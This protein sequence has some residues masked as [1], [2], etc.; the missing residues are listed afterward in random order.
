MRSPG[1]TV[2]YWVR[3]FCLPPAVFAVF[4]FLGLALQF[5]N[6]FAHV[7]FEP[8]GGFILALVW[9]L[10]AHFIA[11]DRKPVASA[12]AFGVGA[13]FAWK[14]IG[15]SYYPENHPQAYQPTHIPILVTIAGGFLGVAV[16]MT[17]EMMKRKP[18]QA[19]DATSEP[20]P[21]AASSSHQG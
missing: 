3:W 4:M 5:L 9:V 20:A 13:M 15:H 6:T 18:N 12:I 11:P 19:S 10:S 8:A 16:S 21:G 14:L 17:I 2:A 7:W 1:K